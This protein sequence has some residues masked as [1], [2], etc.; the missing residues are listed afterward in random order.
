MFS[1]LRGEDGSRTF[2]ASV[3]AVLQKLL[4]FVK[5]VG[6]SEAPVDPLIDQIP[7]RRITV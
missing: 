2:A 5:H 6:H 3:T 1:P 7:H 4:I